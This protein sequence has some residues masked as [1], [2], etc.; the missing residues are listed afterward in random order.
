[1]RRASEI[2]LEADFLSIGTNDL[3][4]YA[5]GLDRE[6][7]LASAQTAADPIIL[8]LVRDVVAAAEQHELP[9]E[10]CGEAAG[11]PHLAVVLV[12]LGVRELSASA[13]RL[14]AVRAAIRSVTL[15]V[16]VETANSALGATSAARVL[17]IAADALSAQAG[18][19]RGEVVG[20]LGGV[21]T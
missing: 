16:A 12:G 6:L 10:V 8:G 13:A 9:V 20:G 19:E 5:L 7:P 15:A 1:V 4:Q 2:A 14:D 18:D 11:E 21:V 17:S 3:V